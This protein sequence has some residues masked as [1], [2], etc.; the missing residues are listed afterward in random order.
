MYNLFTMDTSIAFIGQMIRELRLKRGMTLDDLAI[1][2]GCTSSFVSQI[3]KSKATPSISTLYA[4]AK[5]L[6]VSVTDF[7]PKLAE[8]SKV[9][10]AGSRESFHFEGSSIVYSVLS[11]K[12]SHCAITAFFL[13]CKPSFQALPT[14]EMRKHAGEEFFYVLDGVIRFYVGDSIYDLYPGDSIYYL[15]TIPHRTENMSNQPAFLL[16]L[17]SPSFF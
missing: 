17:S 1:K 2:S 4:I 16:S 10:R 15:S 8:P 14:D 7:F 13:E 12:F 9:T 6:E 3:E 5:V 11:A